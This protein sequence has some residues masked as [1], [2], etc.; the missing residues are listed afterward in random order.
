VVVLYSVEG[1]EPDTCMFGKLLLCKECPLSFP[2]HLNAYLHHLRLSGLCRYFTTNG[3]QTVYKR[4]EDGI[5]SM[6]D[7]GM[8]PQVVGHPG[9]RTTRRHL[10]AIEKSSAPR[11]HPSTDDHDDTVEAHYAC[12]ER[13]CACLEGWVFVGYIDED[14]QERE[15]SYR[16]RRC[17]AS[18]R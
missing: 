6:S 8:A 2:L 18:P 3:K 1:C 4:Q 17:A 16:C 13:P 5:M 11:A 15:A 9:A 14:A 10:M 12:L 7:K